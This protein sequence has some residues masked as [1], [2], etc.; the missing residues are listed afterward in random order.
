MPARRVPCNFENKPTKE[1]P[2]FSGHGGS[3]GVVD[4]G[5]R[6]PARRWK[7]RRWHS[8][9]GGH[10]G[11]DGTRLCHAIHTWCPVGRCTATRTHVH[12]LRAQ[13]WGRPRGG[14]AGKSGA[15]S[16]PSTGSGATFCGLCV[17][18]N[19]MKPSTGTRLSDDLGS[20]GT[21]QKDVRAGT[22]VPWPHGLD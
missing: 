20:G 4:V 3:H 10:I 7:D 6:R 12:S 16:R 19:T 9:P 8:L 17:A 1:R 13:G 15:V 21:G 11:R 2:R 22:E 5:P 18:W 14:N